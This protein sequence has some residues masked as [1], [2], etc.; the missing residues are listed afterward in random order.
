MQLIRSIL[1]TISF[2]LTLII[3]FIIAIPTLILPS[4]ATLICGKIL[5]YLILFLLRFILV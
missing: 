4:K 1:F 2:Y 5:A 3:V